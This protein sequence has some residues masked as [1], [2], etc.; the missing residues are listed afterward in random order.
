MYCIFPHWAKEQ[1][2]AGECPVE[3]KLCF[4]LRTP[5]FKFSLRSRH[6]AKQQLLPCPAGSQEAAADLK[7][8]LAL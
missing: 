3:E 8:F 2:L 4:V 5:D 1:M 6:F 7:P